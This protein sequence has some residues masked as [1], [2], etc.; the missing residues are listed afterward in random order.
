MAPSPL[1][2]ELHFYL[3]PAFQLF[4]Q[5]H[6]T[7]ATQYTNMSFHPPNSSFI[8]TSN[9]TLDALGWP[10]HG[11]DP[12]LNR[13]SVTWLEYGT[14][15]DSERGVDKYPLCTDASQPEVLHTFHQLIGASAAPGCTPDVKPFPGRQVSVRS[16]SIELS[17]TMVFQTEQAGTRSGVW[18][19]SILNPVR[20]T[21]CRS[22][23]STC[24]RT[25]HSV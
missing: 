2:L 1:D 20:N 24:T 8:Q 14:A 25:R 19:R 10:G 13:A 16:R 4:L 23:S 17:D 9:P 22:S 5:L 11:V 21:G 15:T 7:V 12:D 18:D 6:T 3:F